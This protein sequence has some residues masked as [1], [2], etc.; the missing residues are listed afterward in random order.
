MSQRFRSCIVGKDV[1]FIHDI[2]GCI[3]VVGQLLVTDGGAVT[4]CQCT[5]VCIYTCRIIMFLNT[6]LH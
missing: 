5:A 3:G 6:L 2:R 4:Q 1:S